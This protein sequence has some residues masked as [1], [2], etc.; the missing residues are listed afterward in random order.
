MRVCKRYIHDFED[1]CEKF[2][3]P[4]FLNKGRTTTPKTARKNLARNYPFI[5]FICY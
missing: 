2:T 5:F 4:I 3:Y 1:F